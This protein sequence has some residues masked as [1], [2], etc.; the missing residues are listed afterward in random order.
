VVGAS[1]KTVCDDCKRTKTEKK[2]K[3]FF[4]SHEIVQDREKCLLEQGIL[5]MGS[6]TRAGCGVRCPNSNQ[7]CRG[8]YGPAPGVTDQGAKFA[9]ALASIIDSKDPKEI[10]GMLDRLPDFISFAYRFG[11]PASTLQRRHGS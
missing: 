10:E 5:C 3:K 9:S 6:A 2:V 4:R 11:L 8:C 1:E 7:G